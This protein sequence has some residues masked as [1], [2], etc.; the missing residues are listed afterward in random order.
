MRKRSTTKRRTKSVTAQQ[1][2]IPVNGD[3]APPPERVVSTGELRTRF[4][5]PYNR[6]WLW[7][8]AR[9]GGFPSPIKLME[10]GRTMYL[11]SEIIA[12]LRSRPRVVKSAMRS[13]DA[14]TAEER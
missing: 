2:A 3:I 5:I 13:D 6:T 10:G 1:P 14:S 11:E 9:N 12:W 4:G 8:L 7:R